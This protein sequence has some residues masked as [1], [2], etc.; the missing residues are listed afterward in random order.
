IAQ[1][2]VRQLCPHCKKPDGQGRYEAAGCPECDNTGY[3]G[4][5]GIFE[6]LTIDDAVIE[7]IRNG[8]GAGDFAPFTRVNNMSGLRASAMERVKEGATSLAEVLRVLGPPQ[9]GR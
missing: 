8:C 6:L 1:R 9:G 4:R 2:L 7:H 5:T 3:R